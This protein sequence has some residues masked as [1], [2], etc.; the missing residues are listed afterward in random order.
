[1]TGGPY[2]EPPPPKPHEPDPYLLAWAKYRRL[3]N[4]WVSVFFGWPVLVVV[5]MT[6]LTKGVGM[7]E[8]EAANY[9]ALPVFL[10]AATLHFGL[11]HRLTRFPCPR[12]GKPFHG[13]S[14]WN[15][16]LRTCASCG[17]EFGRPKG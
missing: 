10:I 6:L 17:L 11:G 1:V 16:T 13:R 12:C 8:R 3:R 7:P 4:L 15:W 9:V 5:L 2:R 14:P